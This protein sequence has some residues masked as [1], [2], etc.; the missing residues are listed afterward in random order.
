MTPW[1]K[2][3][4]EI[5]LSDRG[6]W[7]FRS[8]E[9]IRIYLIYIYLFYKNIFLGNTKKKTQTGGYTSNPEMYAIELEWEILLIQETLIMNQKE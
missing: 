1:E 6:E 9:M 8:R 4:P 3:L 7:S 2:G 5:A